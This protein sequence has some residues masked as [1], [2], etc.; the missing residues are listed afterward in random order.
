M[1]LEQTGAGAEPGEELDRSPGTLATVPGL[2][3]S[4]PG[5][6]VIPQRPIR[7][8]LGA[9][10]EQRA[11]ARRRLPRCGTSRGSGLRPHA[12]P[13]K[14]GNSVSTK[15]DMEGWLLQPNAL[16]YTR[17]KDPGPE[18]HLTPN[19][20]GTIGASM[21]PPHRGPRSMLPLWA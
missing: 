4:V 1:T 8:C 11:R 20:T 7:L 16:A 12:L 19:Y 14:I 3:V 17:L 10:P 6:R 18:A 2:G 13:R 9:S 21:C 15:T 5:A